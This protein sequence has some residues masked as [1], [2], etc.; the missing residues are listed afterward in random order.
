MII[1]I[2]SKNH[3]GLNSE[4]SDDILDAPYFTLVAK[5]EG[6]LQKVKNLEN[7]FQGNAAVNMADF[8]R[9]VKQAAAEKM[10]VKEPKE[11]DLKKRLA[12]NGIELVDGVSG[13]IADILA[14]L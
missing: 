4:V 3:M 12:E 1:L 2:A 6:K 7:V 8:L 9:F 14:K 5:E 11:P 13:R 10:V